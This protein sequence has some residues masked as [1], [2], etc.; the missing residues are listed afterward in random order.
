MATKEISA[1]KR[2]AYPGRLGKRPKR[3]TVFALERLASR[4]CGEPAN[5]ELPLLGEL[6]DHYGIPKGDNACWV[7]LAVALARD[8][9]PAFRLRK[10]TKIQKASAAPMRLG[11]PR[12]LPN[13]TPA[14]L[15]KLVD[16]VK[17]QDPIN[18][19]ND[20]AALEYM[21]KFDCKEQ[22]LRYLGRGEKTVRTLQNWLS[23]WRR[24][25]SRKSV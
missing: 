6:M 8:H 18:C 10:A 21:I 25:Q 13:M 16:T 19:P 5:W 9:V 3:S 1:R 4:L 11:R 17:E 20:K 23:K 15:A 12:V 7:K 24:S 14:E 22:G 2:V